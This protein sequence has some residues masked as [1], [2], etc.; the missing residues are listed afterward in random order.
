MK[1]RDRLPDN[2]P[3]LVKRV[4]GSLRS[5]LDQSTYASAVVLKSSNPNSATI[6]FIKFADIEVV[7]GKDVVPFLHDSARIVQSCVDGIEAETQ[8]LLRERS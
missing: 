3:I 7:G 8:R 1:F 6:L 2:I 5:A 4:V